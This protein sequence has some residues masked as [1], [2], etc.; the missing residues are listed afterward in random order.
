MYLDNSVQGV[1]FVYVCLQ[2][3][4]LPLH[5]FCE[6]Y[7]GANQLNY[8]SKTN[9]TCGQFGDNLTYNVCR[10]RHF[11]I[12]DKVLCCSEKQSCPFL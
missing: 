9:A 5:Q 6:V 4:T 3:T 11:G 12:M 7:N 2:S 8:W 10:K 1:G